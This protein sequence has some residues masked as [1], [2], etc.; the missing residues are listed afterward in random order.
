MP[1]PAGAAGI[2][3]DVTTPFT[4][5]VTSG[6]STIQNTNFTNFGTFVGTSDDDSFFESAGGLNYNINGGAGVNSLDLTGAPSNTVTL[7][8]PGLGCAAGSNNGAATG[9]G[10]SVTFECMSNVGSS[11]SEY[12]IQ[13]CPSSAPCQP[14]TIDGKGVGKLVLMGDTTGGGVTDHHAGR[15]QTRYG[16]R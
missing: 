12:L 13:P 3:V 11:T 10:I 5:T 2:V 14:A 6:Q 4:G 16:H 7:S 8:Q 1:V 15:D 9:S